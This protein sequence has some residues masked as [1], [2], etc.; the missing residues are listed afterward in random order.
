MSVSQRPDSLLPGTGWS[1]RDR[2]VILKVCRPKR[3]TLPAIPFNLL[4]SKHRFVLIGFVLTWVGYFRIVCYSGCIWN[5]EEKDVTGSLF[6]LKSI[7]VVRIIQLYYFYRDKKNFRKIS[8][9]TFILKMRKTGVLFLFWE[10]WLWWVAAK[11][12]I[13]AFKWFRPVYFMTIYF[14]YLPPDLF[15]KTGNELQGNT[16]MQLW[17]KYQYFIKILNPLKKCYHIEWSTYWN[18]ML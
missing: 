13:K 3:W 9:S 5:S 4:N 10:N 18:T 17:T 16:V 11:V 15:Q 6:P 1:Y 12:E 7:V 8:S 14:S 2:N